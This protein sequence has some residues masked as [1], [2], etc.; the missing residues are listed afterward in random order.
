MF[1]AFTYATPRVE[2]LQLAKEISNTK[3]KQINT[4]N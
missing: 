3:K 4:Q 1:I 2:N